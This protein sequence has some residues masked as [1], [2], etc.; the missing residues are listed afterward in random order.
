MNNIR[1]PCWPSS[2]SWIINKFT[3]PVS[4]IHMALFL[5]IILNPWNHLNIGKGRRSVA[6]FQGQ[7]LGVARCSW[8]FDMVPIRIWWMRGARWRLGVRVLWTFCL[9]SDLRVNFCKQGIVGMVHG[10]WVGWPSWPWR[11][12]FCCVIDIIFCLYCGRQGGKARSEAVRVWMRKD[13]DRTISRQVVVGW[14]RG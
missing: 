2:H 14:R 3:Q 9:V 11:Y 7:T 12:F 1:L 5:E 4:T 13:A 6:H 8:S 10:W